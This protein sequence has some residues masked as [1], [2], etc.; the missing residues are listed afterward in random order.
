MWILLNRIA[1]TG[2]ESGEHNLRMGANH[3]L[4]NGKSV[5]CSFVMAQ[6]IVA[7]WTNHVIGCEG[8]GSCIS[9]EPANLKV[10]IRWIDIVLTATLNLSNIAF[11]QSSAPGSLVGRIPVSNGSLLSP[12]VRHAVSCCR[13]VR[14]YRPCPDAHNLNFRESQIRHVLEKPPE[15][16]FLISVPEVSRSPN[17][18]DDKI[19]IP[20][21]AKSNFGSA[22]D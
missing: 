17:S 4:T 5:T 21:T 15:L 20:C 16:G 1:E 9:G 22:V 10:R 19:G 3:E 12:N 8:R 13:Q 7:A 6:K 2:S 11:R 14:M 18:L